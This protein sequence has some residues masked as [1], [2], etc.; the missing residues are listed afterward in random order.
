MVGKD[1]NMEIRE[2][3]EEIVRKISAVLRRR[4]K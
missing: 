3:K 4:E 2:T 1:G